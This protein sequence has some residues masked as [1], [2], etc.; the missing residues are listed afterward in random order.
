MQMPERSIAIIT[1]QAS[2]GACDVVV[3]D[4]QVS[5]LLFPTNGAGTTLRQE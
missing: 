5:F 2:H 3:V 1:E 4:V